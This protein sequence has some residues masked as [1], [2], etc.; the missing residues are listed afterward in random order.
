MGLGYDHDKVRKEEIQKVTLDEI[1]RVAQKY[2][3]DGKSVEVVVGPPAA[4]AS[5]PLHNPTKT[6]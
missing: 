5:E 1:K 6:P 3:R 2:F 4:K